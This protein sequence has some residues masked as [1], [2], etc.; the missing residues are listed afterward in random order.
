[1]SEEL[2]TVQ[3]IR[4]DLNDILHCPL[5]PE[6]SFKWYEPG[7]ERHW[8]HIQRLADTH[9]EITPDLFVRQFSLDDQILRK[10]Q[11]YLSSSS[12]GFVGTATAWFN[13]DF[14]GQSFARLHWVAIMP[15]YQGRGLAKPLLSTVLNRMVELGHQRAYLNTQTVRIPA[16]NLYASFGF[17]PYIRTAEELEIWSSLQDKLKRPFD[18]DSLAANPVD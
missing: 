10:R 16:I 6:Y 5:P 17:V 11:C 12:D 4:S 18:L 15:D 3:M 9:R 2:I 14:M 1:M 7:F 8:L 13:D